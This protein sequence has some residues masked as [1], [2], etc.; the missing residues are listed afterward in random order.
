MPVFVSRTI[1]SRRRP[2][3]SRCECFTHATGDASVTP[4]GCQELLPHPDPAQGDNL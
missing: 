2:P 3:G 1:A 4:P